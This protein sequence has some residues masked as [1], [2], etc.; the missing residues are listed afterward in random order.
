MA[1]LALVL[2]GSQLVLNLGLR[3]LLQRRRSGHTGVIGVT[4]RLGPA[5]LAA[6]ALEA[7]GIGLSVTAPVLDLTGTL[8][9]LV[10]GPLRWF[11][12]ALGAVGVLGVAVSQHAMGS[13]WRIGVDQERPTGLVTSGP[14]R[15][16][17]NPIY[18]CLVLLA[19]GVALLVP[20]LAAI[21]GAA[22]LVLYV[23]VQARAVE[24]PWLRREH[25][26]AYLAY[27]RRVGRF[28][29]VVGRLRG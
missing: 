4:G 5:E 2:W 21:A 3:E 9:P 16:V 6:G 17:R 26:D 22:I 24:E 19:V 18:S 12:L 1:V 28:V 25:G 8:D 27:A 20:N 23:Q 7:V 15:H 13:S 10:S 29:P 14:F 11:G